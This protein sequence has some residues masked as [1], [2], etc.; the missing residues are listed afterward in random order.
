M[1]ILVTGGSGFIGRHLYKHLQSNSLDVSV[2]SR[3]KSEQSNFYTYDDFFSSDFPNGHYHTLIH[4]AGAAHAKYSDE[5]AFKINVEFSRA[6]FSN[7]IEKGVGKIIFLSSANLFS[8]SVTSITP[9]SDVLPVNQLTN[10]LSTKLQAE[11]ELQEI[12]R[13]AGISYTIIRSPLVYGEEMKANF[14]A[15]AGHINKGRPLP[16]SAIKDN[17][18][19]FVSVYNLADLI[20]TCVIHPGA[21][22]QSFLV[23]DDHDLST[24]QLVSIMA[25]A[26]G[27][28]PFSFPV[29]AFCF[30]VLG[31][32]L[33]KTQAIDKLIGSLRLDINKTKNVL[34]WKPPLSVTQ[35]FEKTFTKN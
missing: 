34:E 10:T 28:R 13:K 4:L 3:E 9:D 19:S 23:S 32:L 17:R 8:S 16:F 18:R 30:K 21:N 15:L 27:K 2:I 24:S 22:N 33:G 25:A 29:P 5:D 1:S 7:A 11:L 6:V 26:Q 35:G 20:R 31:K 14:A 12:A